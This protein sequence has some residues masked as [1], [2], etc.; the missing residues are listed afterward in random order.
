MVLLAGWANYMDGVCA[1]TDR[2]LDVDTA[3]ITNLMTGWN[4]GCGACTPVGP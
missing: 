1:D 4:N 2:D 3:D